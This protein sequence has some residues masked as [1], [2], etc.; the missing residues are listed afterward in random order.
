MVYGGG[1]AAAAAA[2][3]LV[4]RAT[5]VFPQDFPYQLLPHVWAPAI[6]FGASYPLRVLTAIA[7]SC[8]RNIFIP[9]EKMAHSSFSISAAGALMLKTNHLI[10]PIT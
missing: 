6:W 3:V 9:V 8:G 10:G 1:A 7:E 2:A 5:E 4:V